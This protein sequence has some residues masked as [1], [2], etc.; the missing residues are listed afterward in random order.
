MTPA[1]ARGVLALAIHSL[2]PCRPDW[3]G[4]IRAEFDE[5]AANGRATSFALG[6]LVAAWRD[7]P[8]HGEGRLRLTSLA[9]AIGLIVPIAA[10]NVLCALPGFSFMATGHDRFY[11]MLA[12]GNAEQQELA[13]AY[14]A[15]VPM[16]TAGMV[17]LAALHF[18][19]AWAV[20]RRRFDQLL[21]LW[22]AAGLVAGGLLAFALWLFP[23]GW[24]VA[25]TVF[26]A[27]AVELISVPALVWWRRKL[28]VD[29]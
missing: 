26:A 23:T 20:S 13:A 24:G 21:L 8:F 1:F 6:C 15:A 9:V 5:A 11:L 2:R 3:A 19:I 7:L 10:L 17:T 14:R 27:L 29:A 25:F 18:R 28:A 22:P 12:N 16:M 4:A